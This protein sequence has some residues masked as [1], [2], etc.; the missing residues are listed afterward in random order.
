[1]AIS[2]RN[3]VSAWRRRINWLA[4]EQF[5]PCLVAG[6]FVTAIVTLYA[7]ESLWILPGLWQVFF[8]L[9][10]FASCRLLPKATFGVAIFYLA[11]GCACLALARGEMALS[12]WAMGI[13]FG[14]GQLYAAAVLY[15]TLERRDVES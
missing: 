10:I 4:I 12:P 2:E 3:A 5:V 8:S 6:G 15:W 7:P 13:P 9:G 14:A 1:M 11:A